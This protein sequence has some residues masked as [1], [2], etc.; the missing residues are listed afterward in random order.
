MM[1]PA[2]PSMVHVSLKVITNIPEWQR[3]KKIVI[4]SILELDL[5]L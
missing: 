1:I 2:N 4:V 3:K 5:S